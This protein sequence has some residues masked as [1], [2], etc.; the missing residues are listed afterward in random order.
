MIRLVAIPA[1]KM[2]KILEKLGFRLARQKGS[3][4]L[5]QHNDGRSTVVPMHWGEDLGKGLIKA[6][7]SDIEISIE[8]FDRLRQEV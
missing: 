5:F 1:K 8:E 3:H 7:L 6:I 2:R 4:A